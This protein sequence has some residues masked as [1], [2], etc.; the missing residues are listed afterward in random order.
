MSTPF[1]TSSSFIQPP[2]LLPST[3]PKRFSNTARH[4]PLPVLCAKPPNRADAA[5]VAAAPPRLTHQNRSSLPTLFNRPEAVLGIL[6]AA[7][8]LLADFT[9]GL[10]HI[11]TSASPSKE[12]VRKGLND[13][14]ESISLLRAALDGSKQLLRATEDQLDANVMRANSAEKA[15][16]GLGD[17]RD[18]LMSALDQAAKA[19][20]EVSRIERCLE[21]EREGRGLVEGG[22]EKAGQQMEQIGLEMERRE[23]EIDEL[24][25]MVAEVKNWGEEK[26]EGHVKKEVELKEG[27]EETQL[28]FEKVKEERE[29]LAEEARG[30]E[31]RAGTMAEQVSSAALALEETRR[32]LERAESE[33]EEKRAESERVE[34]E[35]LEIDKRSEETKQWK[36]VVE[37][38]EGELRNLQ[39]ELKERDRVVEAVAHESDELRSLLAA[40]DAELREMSERLASAITNEQESGGDSRQSDLKLEEIKNHLDAE[41]IALSAQIARAELKRSDIGA[42]VLDEMDRLAMQLEAE[43]KLLQVGLRKAE[44]TMRLKEH[45]QQRKEGAVEDVL[46]SIGDDNSD[47]MAALGDMSAGL[48]VQNAEAKMASKA[49]STANREEDQVTD[50]EELESTKP[51]AEF[52]DEQKVRLVT[53]GPQGGIVDERYEVIENVPMPYENI[54]NEIHASEGSLMGSYEEATKVSSERVESAATAGEVTGDR[55]EEGAKLEP[56][57]TSDEDGVYS[58]TRA[59]FTSDK[60][61]QMGKR[62]ESGESNRSEAD[63]EKGELVE[64]VAA[65]SEAAKR[66]E[67]GWHQSV[68]LP[69]ELLDSL[70]D[71][72]LQK[73]GDKPKRG[74]AKKEELGRKRRGRPPKNDG[75][76]KDGGEHAKRKRGRPKKNDG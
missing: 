36:R 12:H 6:L 55:I 1:T 15:L 10:V 26:L 58:V 30:M 21:E 66:K 27:I 73:V 69:P 5:P 29:R 50:G 61:E 20:I 68:E 40:R 48:N 14:D 42:D 25:E 65:M 72:T 16:A 34:G 54:A 7:A 64:G 56:P 76:G 24:R 59:S 31:K 3:Y 37:N 41:Q 19:D 43:G 35:S 46:E 23:K 49:G 39:M 33:L 9:R 18:K 8:A 38:M 44:A 4:R 71:M 53:I 45:Q 13:V 75:Q 22:K 63:V 17:S 28:E 70:D 57:G 32:E 52:E 51:A 60:A 74:M 47:G 62:V 11:A 67:K 2:S